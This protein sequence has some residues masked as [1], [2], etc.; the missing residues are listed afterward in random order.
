MRK[1]TI[2]KTAALVMA[3]MMAGAV[4]P[5]AVTAAAQ[6]SVTATSDKNDQAMKAALTTVKKRVTVP[7]ELTEF[8]YSTSQAYG[9]KGFT[10]RWTTPN[11]AERY[12]YLEVSIVGD[13][14]VSYD[15]SV[16]RNNSYEPRFAKLTEE[17]ILEKAKGY[18][19]Q[20]DPS[21]ADKVKYELG[22][23][24]LNLSNATV[25][26]K[27]YEN[28]VEVKDNRGSVT[29]DKDTGELQSF[30]LA[31]AD[32]AKFDDPKTAKTEAEIQE[33]YKNL[34]NLT[35]YYKLTTDWKTKKVTARIVY[36]P[37][38]FSEIDA[39]TGQPSTIWDDMRDADGARLSSV[40]YA[41]TEDSLE[42]DDDASADAGYGEDEVIFTEAELKKIQQDE[43]LL[44]KEQVT[45]LLKKDK[46]VALTDDYALDSY[47]ISTVKDPI[48]VL[49][50]D[51]GTATPD[52]EKEEERF[53]ITVNYK[54]KDALKNSYD[55]YKYINVQLDAE[56]GEIIYMDKYTR[57]AEL[58]R[59][60]VA[61]AKAAAD[62]ASK[63]LGKDIIK[64]YRAD[65]GNDSPVQVWKGRAKTSDGKVVETEEYESSRTFRYNRYVNDIRV[66]G[67]GIYV[68]VDSN[69]EVTSY[70]ASH[71]EAA[72][73]SAD[74]ILTP[75]QAFD[76]LYQ[77][78]KFNYYYDGW[79]AKNGSVKT[80]LIYR[81]DSFYLNAKTGKLCYW[82]GEP[83]SSRVSANDIKY[84]DIKGIPQEKAI[85]T[86]QRY[87]IVLS[88]ENKFD[89]NAEVTDH[90]FRDL[91]ASAI[92]G[93]AVA[94]DVEEG[95]KPPRTLTRELA[96]VIFAEFYDKGG[97]AE[98]TGIFKTPFSD[99]K[100]TDENIGSIAI[101]YA[102]GFI[103]KGNGIFN[104]SK[105][106][107]RA[108]A[109]QMVYDY[110]LLLSADKK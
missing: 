45:E 34:C 84:T 60:N 57:G 40:M 29:V 74:D 6:G 75:E 46:F 22:Y 92:G 89:P 99:V 21:V 27:R 72:F 108:E 35:P 88:Y 25:N 87:G 83:I 26:I 73:P 50:Y 61:K 1:K 37:D 96:A 104:G 24:S 80:Y 28:G 63:A 98:L 82:S 33:A 54:I 97:I 86:L 103:D 41:V 93:Y 49:D 64:E 71:T 85:L 70:R 9:T 58:P 110:L 101:A 109:V 39:F 56:T 23:F 17:Q 51:K 102:K 76:K 20:L 53:Y 48:M 12:K 91:L 106:V 100:S 105:K 77:Q 10:F 68:G 38:M 42:F 65:E 30:S 107:T 55:G 3:A 90:E 44:T 8:H 69:G 47:N 16:G 81:M 18:V 95:A 5:P 59:L 11:N 19:K 52:K 15:Y 94:Y 2:A 31:W 62:E 4:V 43:N 66:S 36:D 78:R 67:D 32:N 79:V 13:I 14:I 7:E